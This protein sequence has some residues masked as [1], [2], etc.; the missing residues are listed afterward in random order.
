M[1]KT[2]AAPGFPI[3]VTPRPPLR[4][5][6]DSHT[7]DSKPDYYKSSIDPYDFA[8]AN[9]LGGLEMNVIKYVT[10]WKKKDGIK[11]LD[12]A[13]NTLLRLKSYAESIE[14]K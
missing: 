5:K 12:K 13:I 3:E 8:L 1:G 4:L 14:S 6:L 10:R 11:D 2:Y 9:N 7:L